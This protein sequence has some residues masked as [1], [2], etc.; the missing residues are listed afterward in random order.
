MLRLLRGILGILQILAKSTRPE[1]SFTS[2]AG[3]HAEDRLQLCTPISCVSS[4]FETTQP[5]HSRGGKH[6]VSGMDHGAVDPG[7]LSG[8][9]DGIDSTPSWR[10]RPTTARGP[11]SRLAVLSGL[12]LAEANQEEMLAF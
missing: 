9:R 1:T 3:L 2:V 6:R 12:H 11:G 8:R 4:V 5:P 7:F 10:R